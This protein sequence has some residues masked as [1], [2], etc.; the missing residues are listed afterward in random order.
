MQGMLQGAARQAFMLAGDA[1]FTLVSSKTGMR[2]TYRVTAPRKDGKLDTDAEVRFVKLLCGNDN[3][4]DFH[5]FGIIRNGHFEHAQRKTRISVEAPG[6]LAFR[7]FASNVES[8]AVEFFHEGRC[9]RCHRKLTVPE[10]VASGLGPEC[11]G[12]I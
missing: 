2:F 8:S 11:A 7:W 4:N 3:E 1:T 5:Y 6:A 10:S 12:R 9:G